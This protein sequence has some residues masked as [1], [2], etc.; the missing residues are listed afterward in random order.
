M[1]STFREIVG[2]PKDAW[3]LLEL[4]LLQILKTVAE[5]ISGTLLF[6]RL[7]RKMSVPGSW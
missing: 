1:I 4:F 6:C 7:V 5:E 2:S 3:E